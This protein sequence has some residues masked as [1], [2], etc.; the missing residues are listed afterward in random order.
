MG[1]SAALKLEKN[2]E[3]VRLAFEHAKGMAYSAEQL[4]ALGEYSGFGGLRPVIYGDGSRE[5]WISNGATTGD[6][7]LYSAF[8]ELYSLLRV[9]LKTDEYEKVVNSLKNS[10]LSAFYTP[11]FV[12]D[13]IYRVMGENGIIPKHIYDPSAGSGVFVT[14]A[15]KMLP[16]KP[17]IT[18]VEKDLLTGMVLH[19]VCNHLGTDAKVHIKG[20]EET[21]HTE[22]GK[23]DLVISNIPFGNFSV[24]D[25]T[26]SDKN[27]TQRIHNYFF[28][29]G[30]DKLA[31]G[32]L[33]VY[34]TT[35]GFLNSAGNAPIREYV[36][37]RADF[38][39]VS[40][41]PDNLMYDTAG[42]E[43]P[44]HLLV[45][46]K[47]SNKK[48]LSLAETS[49][50]KSELGYSPNG[51]YDIN[52]YF[53]QHPELYLG[54][55][56][57]IGKNQYGEANLEVRQ[58]GDLEEIAVKMAQ[59][60]GEGLTTRLDKA[61]FEAIDFSEVMQSRPTIQLNAG[62]ARNI[63]SAD[64]QLGLFDVAPPEV[65]LRAQDYLKTYEERQVLHSSAKVFGTVGIV[66]HSDQE[67]LVCV[68]A[69]DKRSRHFV[70]RIY[71]NGE[72]IVPASRWL[73]NDDF[74]EELG[75]LGGQLKG[76][77]QEYQIEGEAGLAKLLGIERQKR[78]VQME[79]ELSHRIGGLL[80]YGGDILRITKLDE[81][82]EKTDAEAMELNL[83]DEVFYRSYLELRE[84]YVD[85]HTAEK[86]G[87]ETD[88]YR[89]AL[90]ECY[91]RFTGEYGLLNDKRNQR[92]IE[93][94]TMFGLTVLSSLEL[95]SGGT[96]VPADMLQHDVA[97]SVPALKVENVLEGLAICLNM[98]GR[99]DMDYMSEL[100]GK[101]ADRIIEE[102]GDRVFL[103]PETRNWETADQY[104]SGNVVLKLEKAEKS[105]G[106][107]GDN[108]H[109]LRSYEA[110]QKVQPERIP[111]E[112]LDF[113]LGERWIPEN[114]YCR[115]ASQIF[116]TATQ[117]NYF[118]SSDQFKVTIEDE[119][120]ITRKEYAILP[121]SG[122]SI[123]AGTLL[124]YAL[125]NTSPVLTYET[126][127]L[128]TTVRRV[129]NEA[130]QLANDKIS[131]LRD[132]FVNWLMELP[133]EE[134]LDLEKRYN[135]LYNCYVPRKYDGSHLTFPGL[136]LKAAKI[137]ALYSSQV[138]ATWRVVQDRGALIDHEVGLGK[139]MIMI[140]A[141]QEMKRLGL[142]RKSMIIALNANID[143]IVTTYKQAYPNA[144]ILSPG[145]DDFSPKNR[146]RLFHEIK[147][148]SWDCVII[149]HDQF[150]KIPQSL[151]VQE[152]IFQQELDCV[153]KDLDTLRDE[154]GKLTKKMLRGLQIKQENLRN[155]LQVVREELEEKR[156][157]GVTFEDMGID[158]LFVDESHKFKNLTFSTRH[159]RVAGLG[160]LEGSKKAL[161]MLFA[162]RTL[163]KRFDSDL[164]ATFLSGTTI[165]NS[166][167][168]MY[169]IFKYLRPQELA[170]QRIENFDGWAAVFARK[171]IDF[172]FSIT[173]EIVAKERFRH[174]IKVPELALFYNEITDYKTGKHINLDRPVVNEEL[175][176]V[177]Q[178]DAQQDYAVNLMHF[179]R[180][181]DATFIGRETL[182][183]REK[184]WRMLIATD[185]AK[186][187]AVDMR[188]IDPVRYGDEPDNKINT[189]ARNIKEMYL[190][191][192]DYKGTQ[193]VFCDV[194][195]P[196]TKG[197]NV[198][199]GLK[200][201]MVK[202]G[203]PA[204]EIAYIHDWP[205]HKR[206]ELY[207][208][209]NAGEIRVLIGS[210]DKAGTGLNV[211]NRVVAM[212]HL[213]IPWRPIDLAQRNGRGARPGNWLIK[214]FSNNKVKT[215]IYATE[216][217]LDNY[218]FNV[219]KNK[220]LFISQ[221]KNS[222]LTTR[223]IDEGGMDEQ[224]GMNFA[225]YIAVLSGD[226]S[227]LEKSKLQRKIAV[228]ESL[229]TAHYREQSRYERDLNH[230]NEQVPQKSR[231]LEALKADQEIY[232]AALQRKPD[233]TKINPIQLVGFNNPD[234]EAIG[235]F[236]FEKQ[237]DYSEKG[238]YDTR[239]VGTLY[240]FDLYLGRRQSF[241]RACYYYAQRDG[242]PIKYSYGDGVAK[243][244]NAQYNTR[245]FL[246]GIDRV[247][248]LI[249]ST[250]KEI[251]EIEKTRISLEALRAKPF[252]HK[253]ELTVLKKELDDLTREIDMKIK[254]NKNMDEEG[255]SLSTEGPDQPIVS[256]RPSIMEVEPIQKKDRKSMSLHI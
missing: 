39:S 237:W 250:A 116:D 44:T 37:R 2:I 112:M 190:A 32:G 152:E 228:L 43:A 160:N 206:K 143:E 4:E 199:E 155:K 131:R 146:Q 3:A 67:L 104:L 141:S 47:N 214:L 213:D 30:L 247:S 57:V 150:I 189:C 122:K 136:D 23:A 135:E 119:N 48:E 162:V 224:S 252:L 132:E 127:V 54:D 140:L 84:R 157:Q 171:S 8:A 77:E 210:T 80:H 235:K 242:S 200:T 15:L 246:N 14:S 234:P 124:E 195:T 81:I 85:L 7:K 75:R 46:Q 238:M 34:L 225:D 193:I 78:V 62:P 145:L 204:G 183:E 231:I 64:L 12:P 18:A 60:L 24:Y 25:P 166:L 73:N 161:N 248:G 41:C 49:L 223:R 229:H 159:T 65:Q 91:E 142:S 22:N 63:G 114:L 58:E 105:L 236:L 173:N 92:K 203:I 79:K 137:P 187:M 249:E 94:D 151:E 121:K 50:I 108:V 178:S 35:E 21:P 198:Y 168:E 97:Q 56:I 255:F 115:F 120:A 226:T 222:E 185:L 153:R 59:H 70:Y 66:G 113:N 130:T 197:F 163:Q 158:H 68:T 33:L 53:K 55:S 156:D 17:T 28:A 251:S 191:S 5:E 100:L 175:V 176:V 230:L 149:T 218:K 125:E 217:S 186:K 184:D 182:S 179:A 38:V 110:I 194:G 215:F 20:F 61:R 13:T 95:R 167:S 134:K 69:R 192:R 71:S 103:N 245:L 11:V 10:A 174:F 209:M 221:I 188:L 148:N 101:D 109:L 6:M 232:L 106:N 220:Q 172:E 27:L 31:D 16:E 241:G 205:R 82:H 243:E 256:P 147:N 89:T 45:L 1:Y 96:F 253:E 102:L 129:D 42:T 240:G 138:D 211:Q 111:F 88:G 180:T 107:E 165:S 164:C 133:I 117:V 72:G 76:F 144:K 208:K 29:K 128:G 93:L 86:E 207:T 87:G 83:A 177:P 196:G 118:Y 99:V 9:N 227:L 98:R 139:T 40:K 154:G 169:L 26:Y 202:S 233:G 126:E 51:R 219:L 216:M 123:Y 239:K 181:G 36:F 90:R 170:R 212:H 74:S 19:D 52:A 201:S 244:D 254:K